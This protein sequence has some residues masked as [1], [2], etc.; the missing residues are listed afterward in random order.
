M[1]LIIILHS[2]G[3]EIDIIKGDDLAPTISTFT[4]SKTTVNLYSTVKTVLVYF[5]VTA[6]DNISVSGVTIPGAT[7]VNQVILFILFKN[8]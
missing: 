2:Q 8:L 4:A 7:F 1:I 3:I 6:T 5:Y